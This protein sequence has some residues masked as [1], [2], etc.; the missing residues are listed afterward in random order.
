MKGRIRRAELQEI[1]EENDL[2]VRLA[3]M[4]RFPTSKLINALFTFLYSQQEII[5]RRAVSSMGIFV[6]DLANQD[7][8]SAK[9]VLRRLMWNL[10]DESGGIGWGSPEAMGEILARHSGLAAIYAPILLSYADKN[11][12]YLELPMLQRGLLYGILRL[13][14]ERPEFLK[15]SFSHLMA[16]LDADD[17]ALRGIS[18]EILGRIEA[19]EALDALSAITEDRAVYRVFQND[20]IVTRTVADSAR[21]ALSRITEKN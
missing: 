2:S 10:N 21:E 1:L 6:A 14:E 4:R 9:I 19:R 20:R 5:K 7:M 18:A 16:Y 8:E 3:R 17:A 12:N 11:G 13:S 15:D